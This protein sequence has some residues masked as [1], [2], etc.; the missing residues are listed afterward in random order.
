MP[1][2]KRRRSQA[3]LGPCLAPAPAPGAPPAV[4]ALMIDRMAAAT[5]ARRR[6]CRWACPARSRD[7]GCAPVQGR[8]RATRARHDGRRRSRRRGHPRPATDDPRPG[9]PADVVRPRL[10]ITRGNLGRARRDP[11]RCGAPRSCA[12]VRGSPSGS[13][14]GPA[15]AANVRKVS[16]IGSRL[17]AKPPARRGASR[18]GCADLAAIQAAKDL[19]REEHLVVAIREAERRVRGCR[20]V[21]AAHA[22]IGRPRRCPRERLWEEIARAS[23]PSVGCHR[24]WSGGRSR[25]YRFGRRMRR[26][27][28]SAGRPE[29][30][31]RTRPQAH[32]DEVPPT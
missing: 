26:W 12:P 22:H 31:E 5:S 29:R 32:G 14:T 2:R 27:H 16:S 25:P 24:A 23:S 28:G 18:S 21:A 17:G 7:R 11:W 10:A 30:P 20:P 15:R 6:A 3:R 1:G 4:L 13:A 19:R 8:A 9:A